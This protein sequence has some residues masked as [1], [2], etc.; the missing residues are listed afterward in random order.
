MP[1]II[2]VAFDDG[3]CNDRTS[4]LVISVLLMV[5]GTFAYSRSRRTVLQMT[6]LLGGMS[7]SFCC[8]LLDQ[9]AFVGGLA[10]WVTSPASWLAEIGWVLRLWASMTALIA[11]PF[12]IGLAHRALTSGRTAQAG[13]L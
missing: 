7:L 12:L 13:G 1:L 8:A 4:W 3:R 11:A 6:A 10:S 9:A 5:A 2:T